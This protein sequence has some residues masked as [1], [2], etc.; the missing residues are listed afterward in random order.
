VS[1]ETLS[2]GW[3]LARFEE[4]LI[5]PKADLVDGPFGSNLKS[6]E[7][8]ES[9]VPVLKIQNIKADRFVRKHFSYVTKEKSDELSRHSF[10]PG[11]LMITKLGD[12][13]GLCCEVP[14][15]FPAG[16]FVA[17]L[18]RLRLRSDQVSK[19]FLLLAINSQVV[20]RQ[21][22]QIT[23]GTTRP[24]VNLTIVRSLE[25][26]LPP[27]A[28]QKRI[29][30]KIEE[31]F[32]ELD[33]GEESLR[34]ARRQL[35]VYRQ[36][37]L[38]QAFEGKLTAPWRAQHPDLL[39]SPDQ[40]LTRI[41]A[42]REARYDQQ[43]EEW[44]VAVENAERNHEN[45]PPKP[46]ILKPVSGNI[47]IF[48]S[49]YPEEWNSLNLSQ[50]ALELGQGWSPK[51]LNQA[52]DANQ[53]GVMKTTAIQPGRFQPEASKVLPPALSPRPWLGLHHNDILI[54]RAGPR[55]RC[56]VVC[57]VEGD[58]P[59]LL[60]CDKAYRLA[61]SEKCTSSQF[62]EMLLCSPVAA[63]AI[64]KLKTG[65]NDSGVNITQKSFLQIVL[66][67]PS[68]PEQQEIVRVL[69][70]Q[71]EVIEQNEREIDAALKRSEALRQSILRKAF[72][73]QLVP[74]DP[75]DEPASALLERIREEREQAEPKQAGK[76]VVRKGTS[77][78]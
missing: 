23:K 14:N 13:L 56:G 53:W 10:V 34:R 28:E 9:G 38:K 74:Q 48:E 24:R 16:V 8:V 78:S 19:R 59:K 32:S 7:Y 35:G 39:E 4:I 21:F 49:A 71:F 52:A 76:R 33:A 6:S 55:V 1:K 61:F 37:L 68:L 2:P 77:K 72:T 46:S 62:I 40:L 25:I 17:D 69:D 15:D 11:D 57:R 60:L 27:L 5:D 64:E 22:K 44:K 45:K 75:T 58:H 29:V 47:N 65:I 41:Q 31:L 66:P 18:M 12:P 73:G 63:E 20:Q 50:T 30:A 36:S 51:C 70:E 67:L 26:P 54:T 42:E 3:A 43:L